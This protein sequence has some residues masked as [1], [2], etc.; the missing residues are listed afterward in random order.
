MSWTSKEFRR[1]LTSSST[2][3]IWKAALESV[4]GLPP[5][6]PYMNEIEYSTVLFHVAC[7]VGPSPPPPHSHQRSIAHLPRNRGVEEH[8]PQSIGTTEG[9]SVTDACQISKSLLEIPPVVRSSTIRG[10][11]LST[12]SVHRATNVEGGDRC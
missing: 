9:E 12:K 8:V 5:C 2:K 3:N 7:Y 1:V 6:P 10:S 4:D 11:L